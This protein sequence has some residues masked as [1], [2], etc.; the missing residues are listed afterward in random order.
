MYI[1]FWSLELLI[2]LL[3]IYSSRTL[4]VYVRRWLI[5]CNAIL[6]QS[7]VAYPSHHLSYNISI[8]WLIFPENLTY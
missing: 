4:L 2:N 1:Q 6:N 3:F 8:S 5:R 7:E